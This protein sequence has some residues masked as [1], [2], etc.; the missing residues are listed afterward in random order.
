MRDAFYRTLD[1]LQLGLGEGDILELIKIYGAHSSTHVDILRF[2]DDLNEY[3]RETPEFQIELKS[4][5][6]GL[7]GTRVV[8]VI[9]EEAVRNLPKIDAKTQN[10]FKVLTKDILCGLYLKDTDIA[11]WFSKYGTF[12]K[13]CLTSKEFFSVVESLDATM[14]FDKAET[15]V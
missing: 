6:N 10:M 12:K 5:I 13:G 14:V 1:S 8:D 2:K 3:L 4:L 11:G 7:V 9:E 15:L